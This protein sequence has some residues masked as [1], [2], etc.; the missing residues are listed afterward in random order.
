MLPD[1]RGSSLEDVVNVF[2][3]LSI[4]PKPYLFKGDHKF[5]SSNPEAPV[6]ILYAELGT[7][8]FSKLH[9][10]MLSKANKGLIV[11]VLRHFVAVS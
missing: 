2:F 11:Y 6:V 7:S 1:V 4:R 5:P 10:L 3:F 9:Q 8:E